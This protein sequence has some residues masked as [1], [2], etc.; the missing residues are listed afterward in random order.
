MAADLTLTALERDVLS[1]IVESYPRHR[2]QLAAQLANARIV[3]RRMSGVGFFLTFEGDDL[4]LTLA[5][6]ELGDVHAELEGLENGAG[7]ILFIRGGRIDGLQGYTY[8]EH[9][10][11]QEHARRV[12]FEKV[13]RYPKSN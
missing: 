3:S 13:R 8:G 6:F 9:W 2:E 5:N 7:F 4:S 12:Y 10:P 11:A 1:L